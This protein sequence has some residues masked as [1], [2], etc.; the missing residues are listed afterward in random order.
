MC[1]NTSFYDSSHDC[2]HRRQKILLMSDLPRK[3]I[4]KL[5]DNITKDLN[6]IDVLTKRYECCFLLS[7]I[8]AVHLWKKWNISSP[9]KLC[10]GC[11]LVFFRY[12]FIAVICPF[13][14]CNFS[15]L[16]SIS[17]V[18]FNS[19]IKAHHYCFF[20]DSIL[21][22]FGDWKGYSWMPKYF[23]QQVSVLGYD[24]SL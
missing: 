13:G 7:A 24:Y 18:A 20:W 5:A 15:V 21:W 19:K 11:L 10:L 1:L 23:P 22:D 2:G 14:N 12:W 8:T 9:S 6:H 17:K 16:S 3:Q 4:D